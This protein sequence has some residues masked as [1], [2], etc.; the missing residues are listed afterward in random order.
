MVLHPGRVLVYPKASYNLAQANGIDPNS[1]SDPFPED[2]LFPGYMTSQVFGPQWQDEQGDYHRIN[3]GFP[4]VDVLDDFVP[5]PTNAQGGSDVV[6]E[7]LTGPINMLS[8]MIKGPIEAVGGTNLGT[9]GEVH[10]LAEYFDSQIPGINKVSSIT[11]ASPVGTVTNNLPP[12]SGAGLVGSLLGNE[13]GIDWRRA[14]EKGNRDPGFSIEAFINYLT[15]V[16]SS[17]MSTPS[18]QN[19]AEIELRNRIGRQRDQEM[20]G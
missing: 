17:D 15:G 5:D 20:R 1:M 10:S 6:R 14:V 12:I 2:Q 4:S 8:P 9:G 7:L 11:G 19:M 16:S 13:P 18:A 3:P